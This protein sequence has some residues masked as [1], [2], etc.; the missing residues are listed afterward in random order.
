MSRICK[1][2]GA[3]AYSDYCFR[4]KVRGAD[5]DPE[6]KCSHCGSV[7]HYETF[8]FVKYKK[9][10]IAFEST[11]AKTSRQA[12]KK[13]WHRH[14][15]HDEN[16]EWACYLQLSPNCYKKVNYDTL[17]YE[18]VIPKVKAP[19]LRYDHTNIKA[20]CQPCNK[21]KGSQTLE[22]LKDKYPDWRLPGA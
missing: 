1:V 13:E 14:N 16:G 15:P 6:P 21:M 20:S 2:C 18:H 19:E 10:T 12:T 3:G 5:K 17:N 22:Q 8:C 4:H 11:K 9:R 7:W